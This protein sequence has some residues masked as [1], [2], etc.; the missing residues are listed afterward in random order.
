MEGTG[1]VT[2]QMYPEYCKITLTDFGKDPKRPDRVISCLVNQ[3]TNVGDGRVTM[4]LPGGK[5][6]THTLHDS[7]YRDSTWPCQ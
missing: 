6:Q 7:N 2:K 5:T 4:T 1:V 3:C